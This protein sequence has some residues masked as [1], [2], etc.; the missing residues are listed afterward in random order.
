M[1]LWPDWLRDNEPRK[2]SSL[3]SPVLD[4][5]SISTVEQS[6]PA[7]E[8]KASKVTSEWTLDLGHFICSVKAVLK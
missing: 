6:I 5:E 2:D 8:Q 4:Q 3:V 1:E 7:G